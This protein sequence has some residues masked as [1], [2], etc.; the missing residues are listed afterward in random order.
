MGMVVPF[1]AHNRTEL[2]PRDLI[3]MTVL[4]AASRR[5]LTVDETCRV[6]TALGGGIW[7]SCPVSVSA[8]IEEMLRGGNLRAGTT[9]GDPEGRVRIKTT[10]DGLQTLA[11]LSLVALPAAGTPLGQ[12]ARRVCEAFHEVLAETGGEVGN[13]APVVH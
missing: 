1:P 10:E 6:A 2:Q 5:A 9:C 7:S 8:C 12:V 3:W 13:G 4:A 11:M